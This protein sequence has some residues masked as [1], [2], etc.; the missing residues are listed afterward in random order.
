MPEIK[1]AK[2]LQTADYWEN[3]TTHWEDENKV[4]KENSAPEDLRELLL[5][6]WSKGAVFGG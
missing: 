4:L 1:I 3:I 5:P 2:H 6:S